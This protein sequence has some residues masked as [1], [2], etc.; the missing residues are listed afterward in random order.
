MNMNDFLKEPNWDLAVCRIEKRYQGVLASI[1]NE[2]VAAVYVWKNTKDKQK[3]VMPVFSEYVLDPIAYT[4]KA[5]D[6]PALIRVMQWNSYEEAHLW[7][8]L[9]GYVVEE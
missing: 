3:N 7:L 8:S 6:N 9:H 1:S 4:E 2:V 5:I